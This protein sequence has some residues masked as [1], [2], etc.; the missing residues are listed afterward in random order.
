MKQSIVLFAL[1][2]L[3]F[4]ALARDNPEAFYTRLFASRLQGARIEVTAPDKT[5]CDILTAAYALEVDF[6]NKWAEAIGQ[7]LHY[8]LQFNRKAGIVLIMERP[9][10]Y[11]YLRRLYSVIA[12]Y[13]LPVTVWTIT[14]PAKSKSGQSVIKRYNPP[15]QSAGTQNSGQLDTL[16]KAAE[17]PVER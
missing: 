5:R 4:T 16:Q 10:D 9:G 3:C 8:S 13:K 6:A 17:S 15:Q 1:L 7:S 12:G 11:K 2:L 14:S